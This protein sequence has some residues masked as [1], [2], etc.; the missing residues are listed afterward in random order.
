MLVLHTHYCIDVNKGVLSSPLWRCELFECFQLYDDAVARWQV[1][2]ARRWTNMSVQQVQAN[3][4][5]TESIEVRDVQ[6]VQANVH[7]AE[8]IEVLNVQQVH[9]NVHVAESIEVPNVQQVHGNVHVSESIEI[10][11]VQQ[12]QANVIESSQVLNVQQVQADVHVTERSV[13]SADEEHR[14]CFT[15]DE[16]FHGGGC[17]RLSGDGR[18]RVTKSVSRA[19]THTLVCVAVVMATPLQGFTQFI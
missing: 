8:S 18:R 2:F 3:V 4:H 10:R 15:T 16:A 11:D 9:G 7:V 12:V 19:H 1:V 17:L 14:V 13:V 6:Q 5:V